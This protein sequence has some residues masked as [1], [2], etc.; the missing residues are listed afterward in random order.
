MHEA[1]SHEAQEAHNVGIVEDLHTTSLSQACVTLGLCLDTDKG[2]G[3]IH[4][5]LRQVD[6]AEGMIHHNGRRRMTSEAQKLIPVVSQSLLCLSP[7]CCNP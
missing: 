5:R 1:K 7:E 2:K 3:M 4:D 6:K